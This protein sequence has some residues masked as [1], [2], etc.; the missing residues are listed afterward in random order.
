M[1]SAQALHSAPLLFLQDV[2]GPVLVT[3]PNTNRRISDISL[4]PLPSTTPSP[5]SGAAGNVY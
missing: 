1:A 4:H 3:R 2:W 5:P